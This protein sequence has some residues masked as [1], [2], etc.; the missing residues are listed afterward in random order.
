M[1]L[2]EWI[3]KDENLKATIK[4]VKGNK[5]AAGMTKCR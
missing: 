2:I 5:G 4:A 3:L 1:E